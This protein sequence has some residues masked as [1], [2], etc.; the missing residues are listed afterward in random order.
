M[1]KYT[2]SSTVDSMT[3][4]GGKKAHVRIED[5]I[6]IFKFKSGVYTTIRLVGPMMGIALH[7]IELTTKDGNKVKIPK[8]CL[9]YDPDRDTID[10]L[11]ECPYCENLHADY[12]AR[13]QYFNNAIIRKLQDKLPSDFD[14]NYSKSERKSGFIDIDSEA[15]TPIK[16]VRVTPG[17]VTKIQALNQLNT[18]KINGKVVPCGVSD[19]L[20]G[21]DIMIKYDANAKNASDAY[22]VQK[23]EHT[24]LTEEENLYLH[25]NI[26][27]AVAEIYED[28]NE[29]LNLAR[30][31]CKIL[32]TKVVNKK[33]G[34]ET[35][36]SEDVELASKAKSKRSR[37][38]ESSEV[39]EEPAKRSKSKRSRVEE[40]S[41]E[42]SDIPY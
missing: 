15:E 31:E 24:P 22:N 40:S 12:K 38:E 39:S 36:Y 35:E 28:L 4:A 27:Y 8:L 23:G 18:H 5:L 42:S 14:E 9:A 2:R 10:S 25:Q 17:V 29:D 6:E 34:L 21:C 11:V 30:A 13:Q 37:V 3:P 26:E 41:E 20:Y 32:M 19:D 7:W 16:V 33:D 1:P